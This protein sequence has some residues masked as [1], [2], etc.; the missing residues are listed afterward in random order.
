M[1]IITRLQ[2]IITKKL[3]EKNSLISNLSIY[4]ELKTITQEEYDSLLALIEENP[5]DTDSMVSHYSNEIYIMLSR[6]I[7]KGAYSAEQ[8]SEMV[9]NFSI[10]KS[11][12]NIELVMLADQIKDKYYPAIN[13]TNNQIN[14]INTQIN[15]TISET[16]INTI[17]NN[18]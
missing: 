13:N 7:E 8:I 5:S 6:Q 11:I 15:S 10:A 18:A 17:I 16:N 3:Y 9:T 4:L 1:N 14:S 2:K 12:N